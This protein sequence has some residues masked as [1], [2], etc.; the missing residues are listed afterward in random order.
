MYSPDLIQRIFN[1]KSNGDESNFQRVFNDLR[2]RRFDFI[3]DFEFGER[4]IYWTCFESK[5]Y[6]DIIK[7][8][9]EYVY[10]YLWD[11]S[12]EFEV[13]IPGHTQIE[14]L[15][16]PMTER[17][18]FFHSLWVIGSLFPALDNYPTRPLKIKLQHIRRQDYSPIHKLSFWLKK[19]LEQYEALRKPIFE[20]IDYPK[21]ENDEKS[22]R[23]I[24]NRK[25]Q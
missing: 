8:R 25:R 13:F 4:K 1:E 19:M 22:W 7:E 6:N 11:E 9:D 3:Y 10:F 14:D 16:K 15:G 12:L 20:S 24:V 5:N 23:R 18:P 17:T 2:A 21:T